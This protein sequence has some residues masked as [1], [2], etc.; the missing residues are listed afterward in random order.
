MIIKYT[1]FSNGIHQLKLS[2]PVRKLGLSELFFGDVE[3]Y[4]RMDK[5]PHQIVLGCDLKA[6]TKMI[7]DRCNNEFETDIHN[8]FLLS[9]IFSKAP[10][11]R[12]DYEIKYLSPDQDKIDLGS[13]VFEYAELSIPMKK[14]C[15]EDCKGLC[16]RCGT[17]L[18]DAECSCS[19][20]TKNDI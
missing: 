8:H 18:N 7:C 1:N 10:Q 17:N 19:S 3:L 20:E 12:D 9:Y 4:C 13:D 16:P 6:H 11:K 15:R 5:S 14:L 2:E